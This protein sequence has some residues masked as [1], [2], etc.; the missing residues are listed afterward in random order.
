MIEYGKIEK[1]IKNRGFGFIKSINPQSKLYNIDVF[2]HIKNVKKF[3]KYLIKFSEQNLENIYLWFTWKEGLKGKEV[4]NFYLSARNIPND[5]Q[6]AIMKEYSNI[7]KE[8]NIKLTNENLIST[9]QKRNKKS[10]LQNNK[11]NTLKKLNKIQL[12]ELDSLISDMKKH[13]FKLS[14]QLTK[15]LKNNNLQALYPNIVGIITMN[16]TKGDFLF[17]GGL[18]PDIYYYVCEKLELKNNKLEYL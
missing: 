8:L 16:N 7:L 17:E 10:F 13:N 3:E 9:K 12:N 14:S 6:S 18:E 2:F 11:T 1:Y 5:Y 4:V 15:Y